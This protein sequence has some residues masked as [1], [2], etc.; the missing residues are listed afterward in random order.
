MSWQQFY[1]SIELTEDEKEAALLEAKI[2]KYRRELH[3]E[4]W[5]ELEHGMPE[6]RKSKSGKQGSDVMRNV[7]QTSEKDSTSKAI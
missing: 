7:Q 3:K 4:Y 2:R 1:Q 5:E 6:L